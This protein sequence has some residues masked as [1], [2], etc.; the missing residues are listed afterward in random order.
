[1]KATLIPLF[2]TAITAQTG[3]AQEAVTVN[4]TSEVSGKIFEKPLDLSLSHLPRDQNP[5]K[6]DRF[7]PRY[8]VK[9]EWDVDQIVEDTFTH[10]KGID[11]AY[12]NDAE[13]RLVMD[14]SKLSNKEVHF[15]AFVEWDREWERN[16][17]RHGFKDDSSPI[18]GGLTLTFKL[19]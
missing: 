14:F 13:T 5:P 8:K 18:F 7:L 1:M 9:K 10:I 6:D 2:F 15:G 3:V 12:L 11:H 19:P 4:N 17:S 16:A